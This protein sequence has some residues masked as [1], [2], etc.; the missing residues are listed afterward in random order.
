MCVYACV[1]CVCVCVCVCLCLCVDVFMRV[2]SCVLASA[3]V[4]WKRRRRRR[5]R[6]RKVYSKLTQEDKG[7]RGWS[8]NYIHSVTFIAVYHSTLNTAL[9][10]QYCVHSTVY[11]VHSTVKTVLCTISTL[12][13]V[14]VLCT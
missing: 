7:T 3:G 9:C 13:I 6:G 12:Y 4:D 11:I 10:T 2:W 8:S 14:L 5:R 1:L